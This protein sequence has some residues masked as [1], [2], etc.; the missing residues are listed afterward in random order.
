M[1]K[2][3]IFL[4]F[5]VCAIIS[6][7]NA[8]E[9]KHTFESK[10]KEIASNIEKITKEEKE[11]LKIQIEAVNAELEKN[12][13]N[14]QQAD[15][16][17]IDL[18]TKSAAKLESRLALEE[19]KLSSLV[20]DKVEGR[21]ENDGIKNTSRSAIVINIDGKDVLND[22]LKRKPKVEKR[23]TSQLVFAFGANN[24]VTDGALANSDFAY[25]RSDF[26]EW[27]V[28]HN[29][30]IMKDNNL[31]HF[32]YGLTFVYNSLNATNNRA[33]QVN[34]DK[35]EL[36]QYPFGLSKDRSYLKNVYLTLPLHLEFD[37]SKD[38][39]VKDK[40]VFQTHRGFRLGVGGFVGYNTNSKQY[41][42]YEV[43]GY[44]I[45]EVQKGNWNV[46]DWN[47]G[48]SAYVGWEETSLYLKYDLN[49]LFQNND[50][51]QNNISL[52]LRFDFN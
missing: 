50:V 3:I 21:L 44:K 1:K 8:Q 40:P 6:K 17:K 36:V 18:A 10:A 47:Y 42:K 39:M 52:G 45:K 33:F 9:G 22:T 24:V 48:L 16:K 30:R 26:F 14:K 2:L 15:D 25:W 4:A 32:K 43:D 19:E 13:I 20:K 12:T 27:G 7:T 5:A 46:N 35:T 37:F 34:G 28:T 51:K 23:T 41:L 49:P 31:L 11:L 38:K 29:T